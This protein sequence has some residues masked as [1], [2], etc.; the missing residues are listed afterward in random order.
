MRILCLNLN[1]E[2][3][4]ALITAM[5]MLF[6]ATLM[7]L[8]VMNSSEIEILLSGAQQRYEDNFN[9]VEGAASFEA[10][11]VGRVVTIN[12]D[13]LT[14][15]PKFRSYTVS[16]PSAPSV[17]SPV[18]TA[19]AIF[20][21]YGSSAVSSGVAAT[22]P[23]DNLLQ[24]ATIAEVDPRFN[25]HYQVRFEG[26]GTSI[27]KEYGAEKFTNYQFKIAASRATTIEMGGNKIGPK[28]SL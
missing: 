2:K 27:P 7:G 6:A 26:A 5:L 11:A 13:F 9:T 19:G 28:I 16:D 8:M 20:N 24:P 12:K 14:S 1:N 18:G 10:A 15:T 22:W 21:P 4:F 25:Y 23:M 17:L 3:G